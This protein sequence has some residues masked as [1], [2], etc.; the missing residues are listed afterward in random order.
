MISVWGVDHLLTKFSNL[1]K[2]LPKKVDEIMETIG[3]V[4]IDEADAAY[5]TAIYDGDNDVTVIQQP[6]WV[7]KHRMQVVA[8]GKTV[9]FIEFGT[10]IMYPDNHP[11]AAKMGAVRGSYGQH[12]GR[13]TT[14]LYDGNPGTNGELVTFT[15]RPLVVT[16]GNPANRCLYHASRRM[17]EE[18]PKVAKKVMAK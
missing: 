17:R 1:E 10:G 2:E 6:V 5:R 16:H 12:R 18:L 13:F 9:S 7:D 14:W 3:N 4:G 15:S 11:D 8:T